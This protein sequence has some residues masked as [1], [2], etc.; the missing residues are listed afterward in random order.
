[1]TDANR[2]VTLSLP[3]LGAIASVTGLLL[4]LAGYVAA[5]LTVTPKID[6]INA[7]LHQ[8]QGYVDALNKGAADDRQA[9]TN[10][11]TGLERETQW[12]KEGVSDLRLN[13]VPKK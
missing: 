1:M 3:T 5:Y 12:I 7:H 6:A 13:L 8:L 11:L 10:R 4:L 2:D 9:M